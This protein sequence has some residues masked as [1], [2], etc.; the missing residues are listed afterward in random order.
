MLATVLAIHYGFTVVV[1]LALG[2]YIL[3]A[4]VLYRPVDQAHMAEL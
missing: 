3:A 1:G 2:L 4:A